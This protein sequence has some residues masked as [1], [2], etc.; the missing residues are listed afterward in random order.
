[1]MLLYSPQSDNNVNEFNI[2]SSG[3]S[4]YVNFQNILLIIRRCKIFYTLLIIIHKFKFK[5]TV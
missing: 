3:F 4:I 5:V 1:M 2:S